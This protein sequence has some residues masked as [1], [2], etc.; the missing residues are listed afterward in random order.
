MFNVYKDRVKLFDFDNLNKHKNIIQ[1]VTTREGGYSRA[2]FDSMNLSVT[3]G[4][5]PDSV[6][7][8]RRLLATIIGISVSRFA[9]CKQ[10]HG[11]K[12]VEINSNTNVEPSNDFN[13]ITE[14]D[15][16]IT[17][18]SGICI[19]V[20][21]ADCVPIIFFDPT[22]KAIGVAHA[23]W[24]GTVKQIAQKTVQELVS[25]Y[26]SNPKDIVAGIGPSIGPCCYEVGPEVVAEF[27]KMYDNTN[28]IISNRTEEGKA[29]LDLWLANKIQLMQAGIDESNIE[30][31][32]LCTCCKSELF[33]S[34]RCLGQK[35]GRFAAGI[36]LR[37]E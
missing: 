1:F 7:K 14:A 27:D 11:N 15:A 32:G 3:V 36:V 18:T 31:A 17:D 35:S 24:R 4:D 16:I 19:M 10:V 8:N 20:L 2:P 6:G 34:F 23:G 29:H 25:K 28:N 37:E 5:N 26:D 9:I 30:I 13:I 21:V 12:I 22:K 33:F